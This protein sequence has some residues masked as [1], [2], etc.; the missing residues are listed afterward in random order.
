MTRL[1]LA[2]LFLCASTLFGQGTDLGAIRG[3]V[4]DASGGTVPNATVSII[5]VA[6]DSRQ[7]IKTNNAGEFEAKQPQIR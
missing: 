1:S 3:V 7:T 4:T 5:D 6:T 2:I